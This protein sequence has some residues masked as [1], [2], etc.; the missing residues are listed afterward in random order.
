MCFFVCQVLVKDLL[1]DPENRLVEGTEPALASALPKGR[2]FG[3]PFCP[4]LTFRRIPTMVEIDE[5]LTKSLALNN[6]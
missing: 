2:C 4:F 5:D 1:Q 3:C 6:G